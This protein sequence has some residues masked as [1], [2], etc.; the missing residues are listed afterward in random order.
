MQ[1]SSSISLRRW[2]LF[3]SCCIL[4]V[5]ATG[6]QTAQHDVRMLKVGL[7]TPLSGPYNAEGT[8]WLLAA[9]LAVEQWNATHEYSPYWIELV[10]HDETEGP[11]V[12]RRLALDP[13]VL[14]VIGYTG[15]ELSVQTTSTYWAAALPLLTVGPVAYDSP[16]SGPPRLLRLAADYSAQAEGIS[17]FLEL[18]L[19]ASSAAL[20]TGSDPMHRRWLLDL[21]RAL[22]TR[23]VRTAVIAP[24][25]A[26]SADYRSVAQLVLGEEVGAVVVAASPAEV[27]DFQR[28]YSLLESPPPL[29]FIN[30]SKPAVTTE[31]LSSVEQLYW[32]TSAGAAFEKPEL[33]P[34]EE[35]S[36][37]HLGETLS[38][39]AALVYDGVLLLL[40]AYLR[41]FEQDVEPT[42]DA[43]WMELRE[44]GTYYG[45][46]RSYQFDENGGLIE[47]VT[48]LLQ[49]TAD[50][51]CCVLVPQL[52]VQQ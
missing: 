42:R 37:Q 6:C 15:G 33:P 49:V 32:L 41:V 50:G 39:Q 44:A 1:L 31:A 36:Q 9:K 21:E 10:T 3:A 17:A 25:P 24:L 16:K 51:A 27:L 38:P 20:V 28:A 46:L 13:E 23:S 11:D 4:L 43:V 30:T 29:I 52:S 7:V 8:R 48:S 5:A 22:A 40:Q 12:A 26:D 2:L 47:P 45:I 14:G 18:Q 34:F 19:Q 35:P